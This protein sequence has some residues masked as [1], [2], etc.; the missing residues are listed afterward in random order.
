MKIL[1]IEDEARTAEYLL[2]GLTESGFVVDIAAN[3]MDGAHLASE[4]RY[5]LI[6]LD[7]MLPGADGWSVIKMIRQKSDVPVLFLTA[8]DDVADRVRGFE[9]GADDYLVKP[10]AFAELLAR[11]RRC[12]RQSSGRESEHLSVGDLDI[13]VL[14]RKVVRAGV[15]VELTNQEFVLLHLLARRSG[16]VLSRTSIASHVWDVNFDTDTNVVDV[17]IRRLRAKLD[18]PFDTKLIHTVRGMGYV[19]DPH[20]G[21]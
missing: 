7:V 18:E 17:A 16:E 2:K 5:D 10:F 1:V 12:L 3:G 4:V 6:L 21:K 15:K 14:G 8:R 9:L 20:R 19:L 11:I 13:D